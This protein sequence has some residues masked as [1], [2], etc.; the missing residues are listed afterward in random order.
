MAD[1]AVDAILNN[2]LKVGV[3]SVFYDVAVVVSGWVGVGGDASTDAPSS[4]A[5]F[6]VP[7]A[8]V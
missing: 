1:T 6:F 3:V 4:G 5:A 7:C 8:G 2:H